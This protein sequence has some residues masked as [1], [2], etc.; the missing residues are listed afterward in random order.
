MTAAMEAPLGRSN[1]TW[2][3]CNRRFED[4]ERSV[5]VSMGEEE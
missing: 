1:P 3:M 4:R 5:L 2:M